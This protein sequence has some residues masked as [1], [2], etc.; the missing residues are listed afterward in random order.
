VC[1]YIN[2]RT[3]LADNEKIL[4][5]LKSQ[6]EGLDNFDLVN[7]TRSLVV[8]LNVKRVEKKNLIDWK[9]FLFSDMLMHCKPLSKNK[10]QFKGRLYY[11]MLRVTELY[12]NESNKHLSQSHMT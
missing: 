5:E 8:E 3:K 7:P 9:V 12:D 6:I 1:Q 11:D 2:E 10:L 4:T